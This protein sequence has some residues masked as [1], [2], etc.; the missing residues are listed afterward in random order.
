MLQKNPV[1]V[2]I[3]A[4]CGSIAED[5]PSL[6]FENI[7]AAF[8]ILEKYEPLEDSLKMPVSIWS[9]NGCQ[10][11]AFIKYAQD[12]AKPFLPDGCF[13]WF[14]LLTS[15][16][17]AKASRRSF[18]STCTGA[19]LWIIRPKGEEAWSSDTMVA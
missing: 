4:I 17:F 13:G 12:L 1:G 11:R 16:S 3:I 14:F 9:N 10:Y 8:S 5:L 19:L 6:P 15:Q 2:P 7:Q 18:S